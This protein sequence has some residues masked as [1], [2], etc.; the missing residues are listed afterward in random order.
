[1]AR[2]AA[3]ELLQLARSERDGLTVYD[4]DE[5][6]RAAAA[7]DDTNVGGARPPL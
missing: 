6:A 1:M 4:V 3:A 5:L 7:P 2:T